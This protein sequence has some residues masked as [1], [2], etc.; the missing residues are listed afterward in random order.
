MGMLSATVREELGSDPAL[1][2]ALRAR[3]RATGPT[4]VSRAGGTGL[5]REGRFTMWSMYRA[6]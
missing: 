4:N 3:R 6:T 5:V 2:R 1:T